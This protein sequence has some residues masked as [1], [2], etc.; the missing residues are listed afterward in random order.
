MT[1]RSKPKPL[2]LSLS[3]QCPTHTRT[4]VR[5]RDHVLI[6]DEPAARE[7]DAEERTSLDI[8]DLLAHLLDQHLELHGAAGGGG[9]HRLG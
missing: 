4:D 7:T 2:T 9:H 5:I 8:L 3:A 6:C 1:V